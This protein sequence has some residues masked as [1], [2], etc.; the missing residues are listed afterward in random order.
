[1]ELLHQTANKSHNSGVLMENLED[2]LFFR[3]PLAEIMR[4]SR[5]KS[6][7]TGGAL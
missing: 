4:H 7:A 2:K 3:Q 1:M 6:V 5:V